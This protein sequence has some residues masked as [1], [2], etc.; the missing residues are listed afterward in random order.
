MDLKGLSTT[1]TTPEASL[2]SVCVSTQ[3][4]WANMNG[5]K[6]RHRYTIT[7]EAGPSCD[8]ELATRQLRGLLKVA[9]RV[10]GF[11]CTLAEPQTAQDTPQQTQGGS[12]ERWK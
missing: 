10:F 11:R 8:E 7:L 5:R 12:D 4:R 6:P 3:E 9:L 2:P 1:A